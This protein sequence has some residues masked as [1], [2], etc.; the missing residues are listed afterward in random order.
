MDLKVYY[1]K[2]REVEAQIVEEF[3]VVL[4]RETS[5]GGKAGVYTE[6]PKRLAA[7]LV[8]DGLAALAKQDDGE[9][10]RASLREALRTA[11]E[12]A[13]ASKVE[14]RVVSAAELERLKG[15]GKK[16]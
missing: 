4:S 7:K 15:K 6:V 11:E 16:E 14:L 3:P 9:A 12:L 5:D 13:M 2:I 8:V 1:S 10:F